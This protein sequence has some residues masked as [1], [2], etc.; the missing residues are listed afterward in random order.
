MA[1]I[2][3]DREF[4][5]YVAENRRYWDAMA[6][7]WVAA[8]ERAWQAQAA[9]WGCWQIPEEELGLLPADLS[10]KVAI[11]LGCG[12]GYVS[13]WLARRGA[14]VV[15]IDN[16]ERQ[17]ATAERLAREHGVALKLHH[18]NAEEVPY[19]DQYFDFA[20]SEYGAA[21]WCDPMKWIPEAHRLLKP[22]GELVFLGNAPLLV[23]CTPPNGAECEPRLQRDYFGLRR[24]DW[25]NDEFDPGGIEFNLMISDW[26][27]LFRETGFE[28]LDYLELQAPPGSPSR[29]GIPGSW[30]ESWPAEHVWKLRR[31]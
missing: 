6:E 7:E 8:G 22:G 31:L 11:E 14:E 25:T 21:I 4:P 5:E 29:Y 30:A 24:L 2:D 17:L 13:A 3:T 20:I 28:V 23:I 16:S 26:L 18:G 15:G 9:H 19:P 1:N 12:T 27:R 10:G